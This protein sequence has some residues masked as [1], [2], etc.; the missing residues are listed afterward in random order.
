MKAIIT[1]ALASML[2]AATPSFADSMASGEIVKV[3]TKRNKLTIKH[4]PIEA[5]N[6]DAMTM[7][8]DVAEPSM[9]EGLAPG[10]A[11]SFHADRVKGKLTVI[12]IE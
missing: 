5:L 6:M 2:M 10:K 11:V 9:V 8:Y 7:V 3:D 12:E 4:G 1:A